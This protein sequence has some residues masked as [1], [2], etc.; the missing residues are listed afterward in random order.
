MVLGA[1]ILNQ[2]FFKFCLS[3]LAFCLPK[4]KCTCK[5]LNVGGWT[6]K[7]NENIKK[8]KQ[9][10]KWTV[11]FINGKQFHVGRSHEKKLKWLWKSYCVGTHSG[12]FSP[13]F[14]FF[15][16]LLVLIFQ[17]QYITKFLTESHEIFLYKH[18]THFLQI[19]MTP[20]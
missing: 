8:K 15:P 19:L 10:L 2:F 13:F 9:N 3:L 16:L 7:K 12:Y 1:L 4:Y 18:H 20:N 5:E 11:I 6:N 17:L 14:F